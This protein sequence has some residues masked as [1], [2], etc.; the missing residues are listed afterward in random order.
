MPAKRY[1]Y[2]V[3]ATR[4][5]TLQDRDWQHGGIVPTYQAEVVYMG[6]SE[7]IASWHFTRACRAQQHDELAYSVTLKRGHEV[8]AE[9]KPL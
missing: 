3:L 6:P 9:V 7:R 8:L 5:A 2:T 1:N 4:Y